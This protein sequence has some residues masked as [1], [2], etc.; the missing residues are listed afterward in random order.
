MKVSRHERLGAISKPCKAGTESKH[1]KVIRTYT[2]M[3]RSIRNEFWRCAK[4]RSELRGTT[5]L[6]NKADPFLRKQHKK[7]LKP[8]TFCD[9]SLSQHGVAFFIKR[10][11]QKKTRVMSAA[12]KKTVPPLHIET[13]IIAHV[14]MSGVPWK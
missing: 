1:S 11:R 12:N 3:D 7:T 10:L 14:I 9:H 4:L 5:L 8:Y 6:S 13:R 2:T